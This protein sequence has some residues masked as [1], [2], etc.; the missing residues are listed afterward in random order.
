[1]GVRPA[2]PRA[3]ELEVQ[4][5]VGDLV[6]REAADVVVAAVGGDGA[7]ASGDARGVQHA[8]ADGPR[9]QPAAVADQQVLEV[10]GE[11]HRQRPAQ[12]HRVARPAVQRAARQGQAPAPRVR[13]RIRGGRQPGAGDRGAHAR[14]LAGAQQ[15][16]GGPRR[17][18][19]ILLRARERDVRERREP[20]APDGAAGLVAEQPGLELPRGDGLQRGVDDPLR[21]GVARERHGRLLGAGSRAAPGEQAGEQRESAESRTGDATHRDRLSQDCGPRSVGLPAWRTRRSPA[22]RAPRPGPDPYP[23]GPHHRTSR[24]TRRG[25]PP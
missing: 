21:G 17:I 15:R 4:H 24:P 22:M 9:P 2:Q 12:D 20:V 14:R 18:L 23:C 19:P 13:L 10:V 7:R 6:V 16:L 11:R 1:M 3:H 8:P 5:L 25:S